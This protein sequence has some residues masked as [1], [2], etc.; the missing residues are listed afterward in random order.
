MNVD[1]REKMAYQSDVDIYIGMIGGGA[2]SGA[3]TR[4]R[5]NE[6][7]GE[8]RRSITT[9]SQRSKISN[10]ETQDVHN[11]HPLSLQPSHLLHQSPKTIPTK[12]IKQ[13]ANRDPKKNWSQLILVSSALSIWE[14]VA[15][16]PVVVQ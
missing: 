14:T 10:M 5:S 9:K 4:K 1:V 16:R 2:D 8:K 12:Y 15:V 7:I 3:K 11:P 6:S 13:E